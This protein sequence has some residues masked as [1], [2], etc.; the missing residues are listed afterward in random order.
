M[1]YEISG[2]YVSLSALA[3][4]ERA[5]LAPGRHREREGSTVVLET[6]RSSVCEAVAIGG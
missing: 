5:A 6:V 4:S 1:G 3:R 2:T